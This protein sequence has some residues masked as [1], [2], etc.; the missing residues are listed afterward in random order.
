MKKMTVTE[1]NALTDYVVESVLASKRDEVKKSVSTISENE[2]NELL[3]RAEELVRAKNDAYN[4]LEEAK[5]QLY[6]FEKDLFDK[7]FQGR[8]VYVVDGYYSSTTK[9]QEY[10]DDRLFKG[11]KF[12]PDKLRGEVQR[13]LVLKN[14]GS[15]VDVES[16]V[17]ELVAS[18]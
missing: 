17:Q 14:L 12:E 5:K 18:Y 7:N 8:Y 3:A 11:T 15:E 2:L 4:A 13:K 6:E 10:N 9:I 16:F 1:L